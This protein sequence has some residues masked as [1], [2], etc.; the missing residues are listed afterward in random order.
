MTFVLAK[1]AP[2]QTAETVARSIEAKPAQGA[3]A[4]G[5]RARFHRLCRGEHGIPINF[6]LTV[7]LGFIVGV[8]IVG[9]TF[10]LFIRDNIKQFGALKAIGVTNGKIRGMVALQAA[11]IGFIGYSIGLPRDL[12]SRSA[13]AIRIPFKGFYVPGRC[14]S[15]SASLSSD[16][17]RHRLRRAPQGAADR[18]GRGLPLM[19]NPPSPCTASSR[20]SAPDR[21]RSRASRDRCGGL[22]GRAYLSRRRIRIGQDDAHLDHRRDP[23]SDRRL[24][25]CLR[26]E[27]Y[28]LREN[29][30]VKFRLA[31]HRLHLPAV[32]SHPHLTAAENASVPLVAAGMSPSEAVARADE[33]LGA[34]QY[35]AILPAPPRQLSGGQQQRVAIA[36]ALVHSPKL[37]VCDEPTAAL[38]A[39]SGG[40]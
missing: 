21:R 18:A 20:I 30:L 10:S 40:A 9:L 4:A 6:G 39:A 23:L 8:A 19:A 1:A 34:A 7:I 17:V 3:H 38:D 31:K 24:G 32:Q 35:R 5:I 11:W 15:E 33:T 37:V 36:R 16:G 28:D 13:A 29:D 14:W 27:I 2:G 12:L 25:P 22:S 26:T